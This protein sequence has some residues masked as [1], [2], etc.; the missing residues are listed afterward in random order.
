MLR[1]SIDKGKVKN[2]QRLASLITSQVQRFIDR[3]TTASIER[4]ALR[5]L[6]VDGAIKG[7]PLVNLMVEAVQKKKALHKG[8]LS[9]LCNGLLC[10]PQWD[11][12]KLA[13]K[14]ASQELD[15]LSLPSKPKKEVE[16]LAQSLTEEAMGDLELSLS[17]RQAFTMGFPPS[18]LPLKY[19]IVATGNIYD[20]IEQARAAAS[21][22][23]DIVAVIRS[24]AQSLLDY[25]PHGITTEGFGGTYATQENFRLMRQALDEESKCL[26]RYIKLVNYSSGLCMPEIAYMGAHEGLDMLLNDCMYGILFRDINMQRTFTDQYFSRLIC[27]HASIIINTGE[28]NYL[29]TSEPKEAGHVVLASQF[30]NQQFAHRAGLGD[31]LIGLGHAFE[32]DPEMEDGFLYDLAQALLIREVFPQCPIKYMPP[33]RYKTGDIFQ[34][35][36]MDGLF[37][38]VSL[39]SGQHIHLLGMATEAMHNPFLQDRF[40]SLKATDYIFRTTSHLRE[41][42]DLNPRGL[43]AK[44]AKEVLSQAHALLKEIKTMGL[45]K[46]IEK[47]YFAGIKRDLRG[48]RGLEGVVEKSK[49][50]I[51]PILDYLEEKAMRWGPLSLKKKKGLPL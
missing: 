32:M 10:K 29:T 26:G 13:Q 35:Y 34:A 20:D 31:E 12:K 41:E 40:I 6:G 16:A 27:A 43:V 1:V 24:T 21:K 25:V 46:A 2:C 39:L 8:I 36:L 14:V 33:T 45:M 42:L 3:H 47:G 19:V 28:D 30:I 37:D 11:V 22:G 44:R 15:L 4:T 49:D 18:P 9:W 38:L 50:Y 17:G 48:G 7:V 5:F 51:N 23:A